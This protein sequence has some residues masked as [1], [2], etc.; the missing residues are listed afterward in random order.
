MENL[1]PQGKWENMVHGQELR[2]FQHLSLIFNFQNPEGACFHVYSATECLCD[3][4]WETVPL[5][6]SFLPLK[7]IADLMSSSSKIASISDLLEVWNSREP[8]TPAAL[9]TP[10]LSPDLFRPEGR[11][12]REDT[13]VAAA[14]GK[15]AWDLWNSDNFKTHTRVCFLLNSAVQPSAEVWIGGYCL[16]SAKCYVGIPTRFY[17]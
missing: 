7:K 13:L 6:T 11:G 1:S 3:L 8:K 15:C 4:A 2:V 9:G 12:R 16:L 5:W 10:L 14:Q 17:H